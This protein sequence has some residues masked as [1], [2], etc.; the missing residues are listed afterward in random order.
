LETIK[1]GIGCL[2][3]SFVKS[4]TFF[5]FYTEFNLK[6]LPSESENIS[7]FLYRVHAKIRRFAQSN[8]ED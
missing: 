5:A 3:L 7:G 8:P 1:I 6:W 2:L 4:T